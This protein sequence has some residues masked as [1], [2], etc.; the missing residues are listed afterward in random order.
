ML[1]A[2]GPLMV[3][4]ASILLVTVFRLDERGIPTVNHI[5]SGLPSVTVQEWTAVPVQYVGSLYAVASGIVVVGFMESI[6]IS[7]QLASKHGYDIDPSAELVGLGMS[8][9]ASGMFQG[10]P[11]TGS[12]S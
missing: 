4:V 5:P 12:F 6:A 7:K 11:V 2:I 3:S 8:N 10:Y 1:S 9:L